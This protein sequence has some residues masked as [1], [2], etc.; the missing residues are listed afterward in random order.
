MSKI[1]SPLLI[2]LTIGI[3]VW[4]YFNRINIDNSSVTNYFEHRQDSL[5]NAI[6]ILSHTNEELIRHQKQIDSI[7]EVYEKKVNEVDLAVDSILEKK[8]TVS[9]VHTKIAKKV[10][11]FTP[12]QVDSFFTSRYKK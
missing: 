9:E 5:I 10:N 7:I 11:K 1:I 4:F 2:I 12:S 6:N 8:T 3:A